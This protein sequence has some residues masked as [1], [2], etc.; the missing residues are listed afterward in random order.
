MAV[1][2]GAKVVGG[3]AFGRRAFRWDATGAAVT[4]LGT[5]EAKSSGYSDTI[6]S[7]INSSGLAVGRS[8]KYLADKYLGDKAVFW[9]AGSTVATEL[10]VP[11]FGTSSSGDTSIGASA[12]SG[13]GTIVG[14]AQRWFSNGESAGNIPIRWTPGATLGTELGH[15][16]VDDYG[17]YSSYAISVNNAG[18]V[19]GSAVK[20]NS[21]GQTLGTRAV[22]WDAGYTAA[23]ELGSLGT[24]LNVAS[25][26][27]Y[28]QSQSNAVN[29]AGTAVGV[30][31]RYGEKLAVGTRAVRWDAN[32]TVATELGI[33]GTASDGTTYANA[34]AINDAGTAVGLVNKYVG[35]TAVGS[36]A[37]RWS[38]SGT[39][40]TEL[41]NLGTSANGTTSSTAY[42]I[43]GGNYAVGYCSKYDGANLVGD[44]AVVWGTDGI[45]VD[46]NKILPSAFASQWTLTYAYGI[47]D[48]NWISGL[49]AYDPDAA[50]P[51]KAYNRAYLLKLAF[52]GD[53][54]G[55]DDA[56]FN[57]FLVLQ[58]NFG[59]SGTA[60]AFLPSDFNYDG[61][62]DFNDFLILQNH[63]GTS[64]SGTGTAALTIS[65][66]AALQAFASANAV[67]EPATLAVAI[68]SLSFG[69]VRPQRRFTKRA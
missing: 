9:G 65:Q 27:T 62:T 3:S 20:Y 37:V 59:H 49:A 6:V 2:Y 63:F 13:N 14:T 18:T 45:A 16:S 51:L 61:V 68:S 21:S 64:L 38:A 41:G 29:S 19:V 33:L 26:I 53:A 22:R 44:R 23:T 4:E 12:V 50:G 36:R 10:L 60:A 58:N 1:G 43:N 35:G 39:G 47:R 31:N 56:D 67:P 46:L 55:D 24:S 15:I 8:S 48:Q 7:S 11:D 5:L 17:R 42:A 66:V 32:G 52:A 28:T 69:F 25:G 40:A 54:D 34:Y 30:A 57:D